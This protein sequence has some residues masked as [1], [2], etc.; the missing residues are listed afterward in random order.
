MTSDRPVGVTERK[1]AGEIVACLQDRLKSMAAALTHI[2]DVP[3]TITK[4]T[5]GG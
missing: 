3:T 4:M 5:Q 2:K 1:L